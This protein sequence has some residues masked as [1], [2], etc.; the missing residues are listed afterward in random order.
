[1]MWFLIVAS[2]VTLAQ[3]GRLPYIVGGSDAEVGSYPWQASLQIES[4]HVCGASLISSKWLVTAGHCIDRPPGDY[5]VLLGAYDIKSLRRGEPK[6]YYVQSIITH[7]QWKFDGILRYPNDIA[8]ILLKN[9]VDLSSSLIEPINL[10]EQ[11]EDF[12]GN[13][14]CAITGWGSLSTRHGDG[15]N[16]LQQLRV[17]V[18]P[19]DKCRGDVPNYGEWHICVDAPNGSACAGDSGGPLVC[20]KNRQWKLVGDASFVFGDC[21]TNRPTVYG[22]MPYFANWVSQVTGIR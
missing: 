13:P 6:R 2:V 16:N 11:N 17:N 10:P 8:L 18:L 9:D 22:R 19:A 20:E 4:Q 3:A 12:T 14:N 15:P 7:P 1:M 21:D 5:S